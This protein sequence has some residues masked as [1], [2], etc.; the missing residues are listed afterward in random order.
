[1]SYLKRQESV[2]LLLAVI[3]TAG[4]TTGLDAGSIQKTFSGIKKT[5]VT[6]PESILVNWD[7][8]SNCA[9]Y[10][11]YRLGSETESSKIADASVPPYTLKAPLIES[12]RNYSLAV[13]CNRNGKIQGLSTTLSIVT[14]PKFGG[15]LN[16]SIDSSG[17]KPVVVLTWAYPNA[18]EVNFD[19]YAANSPLPTTIN[20]WTLARSGGVG[21]AYTDTKLCSVIGS[22][23]RLGEG[24][25]PA[26]TG[27]Q[28]YMF[29][30]VAHYPDGTYSTDFTG[31]GTYIDVPP[32][33]DAPNCSLTSSGIG[34]DAAT[35]SLFLRCSSTALLASCPAGTISTHAYQGVNGVR[36]SVSD[37]LSG[38]GTLRIQPQTTTTQLN[39][40]A[41][42]NLEIEYVCTAPGLVQKSSVRYDGNPVTR[43]DGSTYTPAK[44]VLKYNSA[45]FVR[46][47]N[48]S[49]TEIP[50]YFG[51]AVAVGDFNCDG[52]PDLAVG[53]PDVTFNQAPYYSKNPQSGAVIIYYGY[54]QTAA[55]GITS[56]DIQYLS[57]S[58]LPPYARMGASLSAGNVNRDYVLRA[59]GNTYSCDDLIVGAPGD[60][61]NNGSYFGEAYVFYG[62]PQK[63]S[64][65]LNLST[66][67]VNN[68]SCHGSIDASVC[69]P[70]RLK[71]D[72]Q[73]TF[74]VDPAYNNKTAASGNEKSAFGFSVAFIRDFNAD[75]Y[76]DIAIGD[77]FCDWDGEIV[78]GLGNGNNYDNRLHDVGCAFVYWGGPNG[79]QNVDIGREPGTVSTR[80]TSTFVKVYPPIPQA[81]MHFGWSVAGGGD[82]DGKLPI[83]LT[84]SAGYLIMAEGND[85]VVG[86][87]DFAYNRPTTE[88]GSISQASA[89]WTPR[90]ADI[91]DPITTREDG[92]LYN[93][94]S[95]L[96]PSKKVTPPLNGAWA[97]VSA[98]TTSL[99][100]PAA[101]TPANPALSTSTG[102]AFAY[103]G[104]SANTEYPIALR[105]GEYYRL[106]VS[107][108]TPAVGQPSTLNL[109]SANVQS[110]QNGSK[111][112][113]LAS[114][115]PGI[116]PVDSFYNCGSRGAPGQASAVA[117]A[118][119]KFWHK[120]VSC[121]AGR[122]NVSWIFPQLK[123][124]DTPVKG[125][126]TNVAI[127]GTKER[128]SIAM[129]ELG[130]DSR[131]QNTASNTYQ[132][133]LLDG[134]KFVPYAQGNVHERIIG[135]SLWEAGVNAG[136][137][138]SGATVMQACEF[139][140]GPVADWSTASY[141]NQTCQ[142]V[143]PV[144]SAIGE[145]YSSI[146]GISAPQNAIIQT[147][148]NHDGYADVLVTANTGEL[149]TFFGNP[150]ADFAYASILTSAG[151]ITKPYSTSSNCTLTQSASYSAVADTNIPFQV[152]GFAHAIESG[153]YNFTSIHPVRP[154]PALSSDP[155]YRLNFLGDTTSVNTQSYDPVVYSA[156]VQIALKAC[157]PQKRSYANPAVSLTTADL[158]DDH[159]VDGVIGFPAE[160]ASTGMARVVL[161]SSSST[162]GLASEFPYN[163]GAANYAQAGQSVKGVNWRFLKVS[164]DSYEVTR[165]DLFVGAPY[166]GKG[167]GAVIA[168]S[169]ADGQQISST[170]PTV[171]TFTVPVPSSLNAQDA[172][173][174]GDINGDGYDDILM[175]VK[176]LDNRGNIYND[177]IIY[178]GS[179]IGPITTPQCLAKQASIT[180]TNGSVIASSDCNASVGG[181][182]ALVDG[183]PIRL[184]QYYNRPA[185][186][187]ANW[188][189][190]IQPAGDIN[191][192]GRSDIYVLDYESSTFY[193]LFGSDIGLMNGSPA[194]GPSSNRTPQIVTRN[195]TLIL[196]GNVSPLN[197]SSSYITSNIAIDRPTGSG[198]TLVHGDFNGDGFEDLAF[199]VPSAYSYQ[200]KL[201]WQ[202]SV[203]NKYGDI[204]YCGYTGN[205]GGA[206]NYTISNPSVGRTLE[207]SGV[208]VVMYGSPTG[209]QTPIDNSGTAVDL[210]YDRFVT[211]DSF[212]HNCRKANSAAPIAYSGLPTGL[213]NSASLATIAGSTGD[214]PH[215]Y[216]RLVYGSITP[217]LN[218]FTI[219]AAAGLSAANINSGKDALDDPTANPSIRR[220]ACVPGAA[221]RDAATCI[222]SIIPNPS[223]YNTNDSFR[224]LPA[225]FGGS[226]TV[227]D[228]NGDGV[229]DLIVGQ[230]AFSHTDSTLGTNPT[231]NGYTVTNA[232][233]VEPV[234]HGAAFVYY[235][236]K[237]FG[238]VAPDAEKYLGNKARGI[239]NSGSTITNS[240][241]FQLYPKFDG[242]NIPA[243]D[244]SEISRNFGANLASGDFNGD[245][246]DDLA[247]STGR[248]QVYVYYGP[249]CQWDNSDNTLIT[250][251]STVADPTVRTMYKFPNFVIGAPTG[252]LSTCQTVKFNNC[253]NGGTCVTNPLFAD[254]A[255]KN[256]A[257]QM[258]QI[259]GI[260][261]TEWMGTTLISARKGHG[262]IKTPGGAAT[263]QI[264]SD[265]IIGGSSVND[266]NASV[267]SYKY[268]G[269]GYV[270]FGHTSG[271]PNFITK[272]GLYIGSPSYNSGIVETSELVAGVPTTRYYY[273]PIIMRPHTTNSSV[274]RF[275]VQQSTVGDV[276][277]DG[278]MDVLMPTVDLD[279]TQ[280]G[281]S[282]SY[283]GGFR[284]F[285]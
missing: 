188:T 80:I 70:V 225:S 17:T 3:A 229:D 32:P 129:L 47:P 8:N 165:R 15:L 39:D 114:V 50:S 198:V 10:G 160:T 106:P 237:G 76:G 105:T 284:L 184:P 18:S 140:G 97:P 203:N 133:Q 161:A 214:I 204:S 157:L 172:K 74:K 252:L 20:T 11:I 206:T 147:D 54:A 94:N 52:K 245:G 235:G 98:W 265:L 268:T 221:A 41:V 73:T 102:I 121:L 173:I 187:S 267:V 199:S 62:H 51:Q 194:M 209:I 238:V 248:G 26:M 21:S 192:D 197:A 183:K 14:W 31:V 282:A 159:I 150:A 104:R 247:I 60:R 115:L 43:P 103:L 146:P 190:Y 189:A 1:M 196:N 127:A 232:P 258:I 93:F 122:N 250:G 170:T 28:G 81:N 185:G 230:T 69:D 92:T 260:T 96:N 275:F 227:A 132:R 13:G 156:S 241:V 164:A 210:D 100:D 95:D 87:P 201:G 163:S 249:V 176:R 68:S 274:G 53:L 212:Y 46:A 6:G 177:A 12:E 116:N 138:V 29:K 153:G 9:G 124:T 57:F 107:I 143:R 4:C 179:A 136:T 191:A 278:R 23:A 154:Q 110:R 283:G 112:I 34:A 88:A 162:G 272:G 262:N 251:V 126:G 158:N 90:T 213:G 144:R 219:N 145:S 226:L 233:G 16:S 56:N 236:A 65:P 216:S 167:N 86:A 222:T 175:P 254:V 37:S 142:N 44:P 224:N 48:E 113:Q 243:I 77:P 255:V 271:D 280:D 151:T 30:I 33:F 134:S 152:F 141:T 49:K 66:L 253:T 35:S 38:V 239:D 261:G 244:T 178:F 63:F 218:G 27:G 42:E 281:T 128:N 7:T 166:Q 180:K 155:A 211:C 195:S 5:T 131:I 24:S 259:S 83:P 208:V 59:D 202:C 186:F 168:Y 99:P 182:S 108:N 220:P 22:Q 75:G 117:D 246:L 200:M 215:Q 123:D 257:P 45:E 111:G 55:G 148:I 149:Y 125:F 139:I 174:L 264:A 276:N 19:I 135:D 223:F 137:I 193:A 89:A 36:I 205:P 270:F 91:A 71:E 64:Q 119:G 242:A 181:L 78:N 72:M 61:R 231:L 256:L 269:L 58:D 130:G 120:H 25:C 277:G 2:L 240:L 118:N 109:I 207:S 279:T 266:P 67:T 171:I 101:L 263:G 82:I 169:G 40:R 234:N 228:I 217:L 79:I 85:F 285:Y 273:S 84:N